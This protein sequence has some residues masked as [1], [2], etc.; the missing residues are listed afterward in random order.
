MQT[1]GSQ[2][3]NLSKPMSV[4]TSE[5]LAILTCLFH[6]RQTKLAN[7]YLIVSDSKSAIKQLDNLSCS[8]SVNPIIVLIVKDVQQIGLNIRFL[9]VKGHSGLKGNERVDPLAKSGFN[10]VINK[11]NITSITDFHS[12]IVREL[13]VE[14]CQFY[15]N[16]GKGLF[17]QSVQKIPCSKAWFRNCQI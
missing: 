9:W 3:F 8:S 7:S 2:V 1:K 11:N 15:M 14:F 16:Y 10:T 13:D 17:Y 12:S 4:Y 6:I 5:L